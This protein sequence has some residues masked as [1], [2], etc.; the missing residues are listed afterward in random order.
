MT[1]GSRTTPSWDDLRILLAVHRERSFLAASKTLG[2]ATSTVARRIEALERGLGR[3]LVHR[4][5]AGTQLDPDAL[6][7]VTLGEEFELGLESL[8]RARQ[9][10][11]VAG[12]VRISISEGFVRPVTRLLARVRVKHP[13]LAIELVSES[14]NADLAR[15]EADIGIRVAKTTSAAV[16]SKAIGRAATAL[17]ASRDYVERRLPSARLSRAVAPLHDWVSFDRGL[18]RL[19]HE[20]WIRAYGASRFVFRS[21][22]SAAIEHAVAAGMGIGLLS[23][24]EGSTSEAL[25]R[26][27]L[28]DTP[29]PAEVFLAFHRDA[30]KT[31]RVRVVLRELEAEMRRLLS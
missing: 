16:V 27:D 5:N 25:V 10:S 11:S 3:P 30:G 8:R 7:L 12:T 6:R 18:E 21:N 1:N 2:V 14:R 13:A 24:A 28:D 31:P 9:D 17:F 29:P 15:R 20:R 4:G 22:S 23:D 26:L 19:P